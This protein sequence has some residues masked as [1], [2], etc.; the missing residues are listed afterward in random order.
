M[1][2]RLG[3]GDVFPNFTAETTAGKLDFYD[4]IDGSWAILF[5]H[6]ADFTP[7]CTTELGAVGKYLPEFEKRGVKV[8]GLSLNSVE[9]HEQWVKDI[10][11]YTPG[12]KITFPIIAD[13]RREL[14]VRFG[15]LDPDEK[16]AAGVAM[17]ARSVFIIGPDKK[18]KLSILYPATTGRNFD[19]ILRVLDSLQLTARHSLATPVNWHAGEKCVVLPTIPQDVA[20]QKFPSGVDVINLPSG[21]KYLRLTDPPKVI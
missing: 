18:L 10:E 17:P 8:I 9:E 6:P 3:L 7:L 5:S 13:P 2:V 15:M 14:A 21:K 16:D 20:E 11:H 19:E 12:S 1:A 4:Y